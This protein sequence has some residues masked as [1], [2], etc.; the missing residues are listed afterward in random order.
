MTPKETPAARARAIETI[1]FC[2]IQRGEQIVKALE[3]QGLV[4]VDKPNPHPPRVRVKMGFGCAFKHPSGR[5]LALSPEDW[6]LWHKAVK[7]VEE[8]GVRVEFYGIEAPSDLL[9]VIAVSYK[10]IDGNEAA[11][12]TWPQPEIWPNWFGALEEARRLL[13]GFPIGE[14][15]GPTWQV[16]LYWASI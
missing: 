3:K 11:S 5:G 14:C 4:V 16:C 15:G 10:E 7:K 12:L 13:S 8:L 1:D 9:L 2:S 6:R